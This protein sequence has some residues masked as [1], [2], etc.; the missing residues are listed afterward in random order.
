MDKRVEELFD[1]ADK[2]IENATLA[3]LV[4]YEKFL[5]FK[6][7]EC[8]DY[9]VPNG[10]EKGL[11]CLKEI[12]TVKKLKEKLEE[13]P[14]DLIVVVPN[15]AWIEWGDPEDVFASSVVR[16]G[17]EVDGFLYID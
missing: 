3:E 9:I 15:R 1:K 11:T 4:A 7:T 6:K 8:E 16:G 13:F 12:I 14:D 5:S 2:F 10:D 17:N